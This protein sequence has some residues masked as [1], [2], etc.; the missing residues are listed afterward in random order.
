MNKTS[1]VTLNQDESLEDL[2]RGGFRLIQ[3]KHGFRFGT[4]S[5]LLA[6]Y[7]ADHYKQ[8]LARSIHVGDLCAGCGAVSFLLAARMPRVNITGIEI[9]SESCQTFQKNIFL[10]QTTD[11]MAVLQADLRKISA[12]HAYQAYAQ[13]FHCLMVNP[14]YQKPERNFVS[15][16]VIP[17]S[18]SKSDALLRSARWED[19]LSLDDLMRAAVYLLRPKGLMFMVHRAHRL[20]EVMHA[21]NQ[22]KLEPVHMRMVQPLPEKRP[23]VFLLTARL[24]GKPGSFHVDPTLVV[25]E[26]P[27]RYSR[28]AALWYGHEPPLTH[29]QLNERIIKSI[30]EEA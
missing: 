13:R 24:Q 16:D 14:P 21:L 6:A 4:D 15:V 11:R 26:Q 22:Y 3:K 5:V 30:N 27:G 19:S 10:N 28:E 18:R 29:E 8:T 7:T 17:D 2:Q 23:S 12:D 25:Q 1:Y 9:S 20:P